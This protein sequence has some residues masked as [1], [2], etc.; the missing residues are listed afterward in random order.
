MID[1]LPIGDSERVSAVAYDAE[2]ERI[3]V[4]FARDGVEWWYGNCPAVVWEE[5][6]N[7]GTSKGQ[8]IAHQLNLHPHGRL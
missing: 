7:P 6:M 1:W 3:L 2:Q 5:F 4:R 8:F